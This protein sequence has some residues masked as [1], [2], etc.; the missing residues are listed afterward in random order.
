MPYSNPL[1]KMR[2]CAPAVH[3]SMRVNKGITAVNSVARCKRSPMSLYISLTL[4][5]LYDSAF[6]YDI[7]SNKFA[8][9]DFQSST[10]DNSTV[11]F[12]QL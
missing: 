11:L 5:N 10:A 4:S 7:S 8:V 2:N 12:I 6:Y 9:M 3:E 1:A